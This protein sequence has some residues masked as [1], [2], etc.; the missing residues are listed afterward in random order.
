MSEPHPAIEC[1]EELLSNNEE[2]K[3]SYNI[4]QESIVDCN[5]LQEE[6]TFEDVDAQSN[7][8]LQKFYE[9]NV[10]G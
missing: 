6:M 10:V 3:V 4:L 9:K 5:K 8:W 2:T 7:L 1:Q